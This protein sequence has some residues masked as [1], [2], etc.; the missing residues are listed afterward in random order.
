MTN[1]DD[2]RYRNKNELARFIADITTCA[3]CPA[4]APCEYIREEGDYDSCD[5]V[6]FDWLISPKEE[7]LHGKQQRFFRVRNN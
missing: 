5:T 1:A 4:R 6:I 2:I 3:K 7:S